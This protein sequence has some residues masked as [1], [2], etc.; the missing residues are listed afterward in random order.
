MSTKVQA[1]KAGKA[2]KAHR[3]NRARKTSRV[4]PKKTILKKTTPRKSTI[5]PAKARSPS[6]RANTSPAVQPSKSDGFSTVVQAFTTDPAVTL[7]GAGKGFG[8]RAL[9]VNGKIFAMISSRAEFVVKLPSQRAAEL[10]ATG[11]TKYFDAGRGKAMK[12]WAVVIAG[13]RLWLAL[14]KEARDFV[15]AGS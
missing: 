8:S 5:Q 11:D 15:G 7:P 6:R 2:S 10:L 12:E 3:S 14:A 13:E 1:S 9:K 4:T